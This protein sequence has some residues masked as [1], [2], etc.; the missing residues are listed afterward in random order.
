MEINLNMESVAQSEIETRSQSFLIYAVDNTVGLH[1]GSAFFL[2][3]YY[4]ALLVKRD[5]EG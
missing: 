3:N 4:R 2:L 5:L 1:V